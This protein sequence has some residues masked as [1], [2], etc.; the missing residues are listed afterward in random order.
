MLPQIILIVL[1]LVLSAQ[2][3]IIHLIRGNKFAMTSSLNFDDG[4]MI[5]CEICQTTCV[6]S[7]F[8]IGCFLLKEK[9]FKMFLHATA[10]K[11]WLV[12]V[13]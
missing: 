8:R 1:M 3:A 6:Q 4:V 11:S 7:S 5:E 12:Q 9:S 13:M 2:H 10:L